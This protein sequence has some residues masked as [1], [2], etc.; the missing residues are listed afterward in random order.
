MDAAI[1][2]C[3]MLWGT[4]MD[5]VMDKMDAAMDKRRDVKGTTM[6]VAM[7]YTSG[8]TIDHGT[9]INKYHAIDVAMDNKKIFH[10]LVFPCQSSE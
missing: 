8:V 2:N 10:F 5:V 7:D 3:G 6:N 1:D 4:K 9:Y